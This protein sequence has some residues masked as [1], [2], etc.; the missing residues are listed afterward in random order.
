MQADGG[1]DGR[2]AAP[3]PR[4]LPRP[5]PPGSGISTYEFRDGWVYI[6]GDVVAINC[7][8]FAEGGDRGRTPF[9]GPVLGRA[10]RR[11]S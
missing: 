8:V 10:R 6:D 2:S 1:F 7:E 4:S 3:A 11:L 5:G 9:R